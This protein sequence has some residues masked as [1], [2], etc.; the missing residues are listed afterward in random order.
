MASQTIRVICPNLKCRSILNIPATARGKTIR[1]G[2]CG[3]RVRVP[4]APAATEQS[5][6][7]APS[8]KD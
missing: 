8:A 4:A 3:F 2:Q 7:A 6:T 1:C 5:G